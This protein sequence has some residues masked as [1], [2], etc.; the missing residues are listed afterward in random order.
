MKRSRLVFLIIGVS[1]IFFGCSKDD[2]PAPEFDQSD[3][4]TASLKSA[5]PSSRL[6]GTMD[7]DFTFGLWP[8]E[9]VWVGTVDFEDYGVFGIRFF[10]LSPFRDYS[11]VSPFEEIF[12]VYDLDNPD[13][14]YMR[15]PD[16]GTTILA[17]KVPDDTKYRMNG[18]V[19]EALEPFE[20]WLGRSVHMNGVITWQVLDTP[21]G[22]VVAP[23][24]APG[25]FYVN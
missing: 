10:H 17:N 13:V 9:P 11:Q 24:T 20:G 3:Q 18:E 5:K 19:E 23:A 7:L 16:V 22:P 2:L 8:E 15:G 21:D 6:I 1:I 12:E 4:A 25:I 14:I